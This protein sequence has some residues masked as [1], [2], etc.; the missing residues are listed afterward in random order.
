MGNQ[1][2]TE[3]SWPANQKQVQYQHQ[4]RTEKGAAIPKTEGNSKCIYS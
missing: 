2:K 4:E 1:L 3:I